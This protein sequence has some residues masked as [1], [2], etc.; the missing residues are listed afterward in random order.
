MYLKPVYVFKIGIRFHSWLGKQA[1]YHE[2][3]VG[4]C[5]VDGVGV[6][7]GCGVYQIESFSW[8]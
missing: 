7:M 3:G 1:E 6:E 8:I 4:V 2:C 5:G